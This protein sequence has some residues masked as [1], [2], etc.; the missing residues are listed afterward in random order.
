MNHPS[1]QLNAPARTFTQLRSCTRRGARLARLLAVFELRSWDVPQELVERA[2]LV[3]AELAANAVLHGTRP[4]DRPGPGFRLTLVYDPS[5]RRL[6]V[7]VTDACGDL[8]PRVPRADGDP[9]ALLHTGGRGLGLVAALADH[10]ETVPH[11]PGGK[12]IRALLSSPAGA[13]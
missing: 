3:I 9:D 1:P 11:P 10:W 5:G 8:C 6:R 13:G 2:E 12:T 4:G 7:D